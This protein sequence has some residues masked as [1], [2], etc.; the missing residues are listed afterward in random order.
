MK[1]LVRVAGIEHRV[2]SPYHPRTNGLTE[3]F[4]GTLV[5]ALKKHAE[6]DPKGWPDWL[7]YILMAYILMAT[8]F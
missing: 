8:Y 6:N 1:E 7:P 4:N 3:R 2:T 5:T